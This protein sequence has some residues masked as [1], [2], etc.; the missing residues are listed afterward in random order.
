MAALMA[1]ADATTTLRIGTLVLSNDYRHPA[2]LAKELPPY[3]PNFMRAV[4]W[5]CV[6]TGGRAVIDAIE[7]NLNLPP[8]VLALTHGGGGGGGGGG[9][10]VSARSREMS[11]FGGT[12]ED[13]GV[14]GMETHTVLFV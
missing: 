7:N 6:H 8:H 14:E 10:D 2:V 4:E 11:A 12:G 3:V 5:V 1:A 13:E 9:G